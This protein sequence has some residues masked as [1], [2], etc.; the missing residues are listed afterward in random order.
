MTKAAD[1]MSSTGAQ[2]AAATPPSHSY[3]QSNA[4]AHM[5][6]GTQRQQQQQVLAGAHHRVA[7]GSQVLRHSSP[8]RNMQQ[9]QQQ[10]LQQ[11]QQPM[12]STGHGMGS[13]PTATVLH[14][15]RTTT[16]VGVHAS[17]A[18]TAAAKQ[19]AGS[20]KQQQ[21]LSHQQPAGAD[22][23]TPRGQ[24][25]FSVRQSCNTPVEKKLFQ[26]LEVCAQSLMSRV[27]NESGDLPAALMPSC[28][29]CLS[30]V[31]QCRAPVVFPAGVVAMLRLAGS[32]A[33][34]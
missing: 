26:Q 20:Q 29:S 7:P 8:N 15:L 31:N 14:Q 9:Q 12:P 1:I 16:A 34:C 5:M 18:S 19:L 3:N 4:D 10:R 24:P 2:A 27:L 17:A 6:C 28:M 33:R 32:Q 11:Q 30:P 22:H 25:M 23:A 13:G 21:Q